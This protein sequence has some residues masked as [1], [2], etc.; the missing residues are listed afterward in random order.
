MLTL[1]HLLACLRLKR[2]KRKKQPVHFQARDDG[3]GLLTHNDQ[4]LHTMMPCL[5]AQN[6]ASV[7]HSRDH[8]M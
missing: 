3:C 5:K 4:L 1:S 8:E 6:K 2:I 7:L